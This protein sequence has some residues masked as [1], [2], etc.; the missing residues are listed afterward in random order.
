MKG[1]NFAPGNKCQRDLEIFINAPF[2]HPIYIGSI[3][4]AHN[5]VSF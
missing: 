4:V 5:G 2:A 1:G 3:Q